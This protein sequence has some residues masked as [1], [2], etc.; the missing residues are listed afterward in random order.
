L[1]QFLHKITPIALRSQV[2]G[3]QVNG[4]PDMSRAG[5]R[6]DQCRSRVAHT[7]GRLWI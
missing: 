6:S 7:G 2:N 3:Q 5:R 4:G 1:H